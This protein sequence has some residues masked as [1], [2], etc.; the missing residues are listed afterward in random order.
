MTIESSDRVITIF[1]DVQ[2]A[3]R[4]P[5]VVKQNEHHPSYE[6]PERVEP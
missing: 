6:V 3:H 5:Y 4:Y 1:S 2:R